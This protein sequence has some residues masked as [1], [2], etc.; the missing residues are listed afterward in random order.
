MPR[1]AIDTDISPERSKQDIERLVQKY[2]AT[3]F[4]AGQTATEAVVAFEMNDRRIMF[5]L[6]MPTH[7]EHDVQFTEQG[8]RR[9]KGQREAYI[10]RLI[11]SGWRALLLSIKAKLEASQV[12]ISTFEEEFLAH[13]VMPDGLTVGDH[14]KPRIVDAY[15]SGKMQPLLPGPKA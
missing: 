6:P 11:R 3:S 12:G 10:K 7:D 5:R 13:I 14:V 4:M 8:R 9:D 1:Y 15:S 2:G